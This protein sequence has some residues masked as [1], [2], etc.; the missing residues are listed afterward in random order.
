MHKLYKE[1]SR[2]INISS[3]NELQAIRS[4]LCRAIDEKLRKYKCTGMVVKQKKLHHKSVKK[5]PDDKKT[6]VQRIR[7]IE[8]ILNQNWKYLYDGQELDETPKYYVYAHCDPTIKMYDISVQTNI[9]GVPFY[10]GKGTGGRAY[11]LVRNQGHDAKVKD[12]IK[13]CLSE[14]SIVRIVRNG[15]TELDAFVLESKLIYIFQTVYEN[16]VDGMLFNLDTGKRPNFNDEDES[17]EPVVVLVKRNTESVRTVDH[18]I[19]NCQP[20]CKSCNSSKG[21]K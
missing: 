5:I 16:Q 6:Y 1:I 3:R 7:Y 21:G 8:F 15:L 12:V 2:V 11:D 9:I 17:K 19:D 4:I 10:I 13:K 20:I 14:K 18:C